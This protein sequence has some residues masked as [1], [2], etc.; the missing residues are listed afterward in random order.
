MQSVL[1]QHVSDAAAGLHHQS[2]TLLYLVVFQT[3]TQW[4][5]WQRT[6]K[7]VLLIYYA[8]CVLVWGSPLFPFELLSSVCR[9]WPARHVF[10]IASVFI[11]NFLSSLV[12]SNILFNCMF[13]CSPRVAIDV[14]LS[15]TC[16]QSTTPSLSIKVTHCSQTS[17][18]SLWRFSSLTLTRRISE[19]Q[20]PSLASSCKEHAS[21]VECWPADGCEF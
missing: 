7:H 5:K 8:V 13:L 18:T 16:V 21:K 19:N 6:L 10:V 14:W 4:L 17:P 3:T 2:A 12:L 9:M 20:S 1:I 11:F 15:W